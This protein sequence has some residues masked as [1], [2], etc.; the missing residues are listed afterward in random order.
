MDIVDTLRYNAPI[1]REHYMHRAA[2]EIER[3]QHNMKV[4]EQTKDSYAELAAQ[5]L[6]EIERLRKERDELVR[7]CDMTLSMLLKE[8]DT[9]SALF[10]AENMLR[11]AIAIVKGGA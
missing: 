5:R 7:I 3:L 11:E 9:V 2:D 6:E 8:P 4:T 1:S 10:K